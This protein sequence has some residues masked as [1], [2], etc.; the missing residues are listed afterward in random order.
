VDLTVRAAALALGTQDNTMISRRTLY[1][2]FA[3]ATVAA[4][5]AFIGLGHPSPSKWS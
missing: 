5:A 2:L 3:M 4:L 1:F